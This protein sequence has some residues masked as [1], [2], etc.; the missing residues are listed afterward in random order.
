MTPNSPS[1]VCVSSIWYDLDREVFTSVKIEPRKEVPR[2]H[3]DKSRNRRRRKRGNRSTLVPDA[4]DECP[5]S[6]EKGTNLML[7]TGPTLRLEDSPTLSRWS[8]EG[9]EVDCGAP[10]S[11]EALAAAVERGPHK[12]ALSEE[13]IQLVHDD[14]E[15]QVKAGFAEI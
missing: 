11:E 1:P 5:R 3:Q 12:G 4:D 15:Y 2:K 10:W 13:A 14:V 6:E 8:S 9:C 7:P